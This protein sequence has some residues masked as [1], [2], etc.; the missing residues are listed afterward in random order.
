MLQLPEPHED[1]RNQVER[2]DI[3]HLDNTRIRDLVENAERYLTKYLTPIA[4]E[5][6]LEEQRQRLNDLEA[7]G[8]QEKE[9]LLRLL[10]LFQDR[11][12][13]SLFYWF[14]NAPMSLAPEQ[15]QLLLRFLDTPIEMPGD[16]TDKMR[17]VDPIALFEEID[18]KQT[19]AN[20]F[21][22]KLGAIHEYIAANAIK[23]QKYLQIPQQLGKLP[24]KL[25]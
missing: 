2:I 21:W 14:M 12:P 10:K 9:R 3:E 25:L 13:G 24:A 20:G 1:W 16:P 8:R 19:S 22:L 11:S 23:A 5:N 4:I 17:Y 18:T 15:R 7:G 6:K